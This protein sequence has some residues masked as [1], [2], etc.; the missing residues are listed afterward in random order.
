MTYQQYTI[1]FVMILK[2]IFLL[3]SGLLDRLKRLV[4]L[5]KTRLVDGDLNSVDLL[6]A[7]QEINQANLSDEQDT[8]EIVFKDIIKISDSFR[9]HQKFHSSLF[10]VW[11]ASTLCKNFTDPDIKIIRLNDCGNSTNYTAKLLCL[12][13]KKE[14]IERYV[15]PMVRNLYEVMRSVE[16]N[17]NILKVHILCKFFGRIGWCYTYINDYENSAEYFSEG[18]ETMIKWFGDDAKQFI[19]TGSSCYQ[20]GKCYRCLQKFNEAT[21]LFE[22]SIKLYKG[23]LDVG[24]EEKKKCIDIAV[25][26]LQ[27]SRAGDSSE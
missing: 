21:E 20:A 2:C 26:Q 24:D 17:T 6:L 16:T 18:L 13:D 25:E 1:N 4:T 9:E 5:I 3:C 27:K 10:M 19:I 15:L 23:V 8:C 11:L 14:D 12:Y 7:I 22:R